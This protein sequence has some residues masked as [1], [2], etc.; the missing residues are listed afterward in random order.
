MPTNPKPVKPVSSFRTARLS[1]NSDWIEQ[2]DQAGLLL[3]LRPRDASNSTPKKWLKTGLEFY[4]DALQLS[5]V[6]CDR[7]ADWSVTP[8]AAV[9]S[10]ADPVTITV[11]RAEGA[12]GTSVWVY[13]HPP[14]GKTKV[15]L[16]EVCW[17]YAE[18]GGEWDLEVAAYAARPEERTT[19]ALG[20][21]FSDFEATWA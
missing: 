17:F 18:E 5:T 14:G 2:Y 7:F 8:L 15:S 20:V 1:F 4:D 19:D 12:H 21:E 13:Y 16:R 3:T 9:G 10:P 6:A 11:E